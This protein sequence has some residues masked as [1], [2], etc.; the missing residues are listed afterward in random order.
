M[1][2]WVIQENIYHEEGFTRLVDALKR[3]G[4][5]YSLHKVIPFAGGIT[6]EPAVPEGTPLIVMGSYSMAIHAR[7]NGWQ[8]GSFDNDNL[9]FEKQLPHWG[10]CMLNHDAHVCR[11][12]AVPPQPKP[13]FLRP[14]LDT[15]SFSGEVTDWHDFRPWQAKVLA[16]G[17]HEGA[18]LTADT[19]VM[20]CK[21][22][23][24]WSEYRL[25]VVDGKVV[26]ASMYKQGSRV[27]YNDGVDDAFIAYGEKIAALWSPGRA[28]VL[29]ICEGIDGLKIVEA[30]CLNAAGFYAADMQKLAMALEA[31]FSG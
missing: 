19:M 23:Q 6:P 27:I 26:T 22:R 12:D 29:D 24:I 17:K 3:L 20:V 14:T 2:H 8:P 10:E 7:A 31:A 21:L 9:D 13:F 28:Y 16:L 15:K 1:M 11:F 25:W 30:G 18:T 4:L 5:S